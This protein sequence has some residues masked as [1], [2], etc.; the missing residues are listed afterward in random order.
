MSITLASLPSPLTLHNNP[1][2]HTH[3][4]DSLTLTAGALTDCF[5]NPITNEKKDNAPYASFVTTDKHFLLSACVQVDFQSTFDAGALQLRVDEHNW[6]K[7]CFEYSPQGSPMIVSVVTK[8]VSDD[9]NSTVIDGD[10]IYLRV[11]RQNNIIA[12]H[13][14]TN[15]TFW[16]FVRY[17]TLGNPDSLTVALS[18]QS[19]TGDTCT[20]T[21]SNINYQQTKLSDLRNGE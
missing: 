19:P 10:S 21:F 5:I 2:H 7:L 8:N 20:S 4:P 15:A 11:A 3:T 6:A 16:H 14:A 17:F 12:F 1:Q 18:S 13:Y 9:C